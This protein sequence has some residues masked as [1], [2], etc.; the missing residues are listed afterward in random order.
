MNERETQA[1]YDEFLAADGDAVRLKATRTDRA[2]AERPDAF[3]SEGCVRAA[4]P[5][6]PHLARH[7]LHET[8][9]GRPRG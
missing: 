7:P 5:A 2:F 6:I 9:E 1:L 4:H 8:R 3:I